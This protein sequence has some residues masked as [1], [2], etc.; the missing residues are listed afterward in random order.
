VRLALGVT[1]RVGMAVVLVMPVSMLVRHGPV[2]MRMLVP[3]G[4]MQP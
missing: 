1:R 4:Q 3:L 2:C